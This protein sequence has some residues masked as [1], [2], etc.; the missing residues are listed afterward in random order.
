MFQD[1]YWSIADGLL[2]FTMI[3]LFI[4]DI[5]TTSP[6]WSAILR[7]RALLRPYRISLL[8]QHIF[9]EDFALLIPPAASTPVEK[10]L[11]ILNKL[12]RQAAKKATVKLNKGDLRYCI[13]QIKGGKLY[14]VDVEKIEQEALDMESLSMI[15]SY[16]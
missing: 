3:L 15:R 13:A 2:I 5:F 10:V 11:E 4:A 8:I 12:K 6:S 16:S 1:Y 14:D 9:T 7:T